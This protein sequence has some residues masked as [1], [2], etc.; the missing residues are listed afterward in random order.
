MRVAVYSLSSTRDNEIRYIGQTARSLKQRLSQHKSY[1][2]KMR[3]TAVHKW[4][5]REMADGFALQITALT[6]RA[7]WNETEIALIAQYRANG[8]RLLNHTDGGEG[9]VGLRL[10]GRKRPDLAE[11]NRKLK[12]MPGRKHTEE[13]KA[14]MSEI[15]TGKKCPWNIE[16][17]KARAGLPGHPHTK[18]FKEAL[19]QRSRGLTV[20]DETRAKISAANSGRKLTEQQIA[21]LRAGHR[22]YWQGKRNAGA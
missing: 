3:Q 15:H 8:A 14:K 13:A 7:V 17:N 16:R 10:V 18:E 22:A 1:A 12:G 21:V 9:T 4:I 6:E 20:S 11:R 2:V 19:A 5:A